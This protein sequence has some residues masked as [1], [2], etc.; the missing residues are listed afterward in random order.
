MEIGDDDEFSEDDMLVFVEFVYYSTYA[1][2]HVFS[3]TLMVQETQ[4]KIFF[5]NYIDELMNMLQKNFSTII[6]NSSIYISIARGL[7]ITFEK[8]LGAAFNTKTLEQKNMEGNSNSLRAIDQNKVSTLN[9][10]GQIESEFKKDRLFSTDSFFNLKNKQIRSFIF[11]TYNDIKDLQTAMDDPDL[12]NRQYKVASRLDYRFTLEIL[13]KTPM[14]QGMIENAQVRQALAN[15]FSGN[16]GMFRNT[17][18]DIDKSIDEFDGTNIEEL[19]TKLQMR[20]PKLAS[21]GPEGMV[22]QFDDR[23]LEMGSAQTDLLSQQ[24]IQKR[25]ELKQLESKQEKVSKMSKQPT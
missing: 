9:E 18:E 25:Q 10:T 17:L 13:G 2:Y 15:I 5:K 4:M 22:F 21:F 6:N 24:V 14:K 7:A 3:T 8:K 19:H 23:L 1:F 11:K 20:I 12:G 16:F